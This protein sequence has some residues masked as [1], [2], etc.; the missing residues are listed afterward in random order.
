[1]A[2]N[3]D[4]A[5][6]LSQGVFIFVY[7]AV[8]TLLEFLIAKTFDA[9]AVLVV[10]ALVKGVLVVYYYMHIY[11]LNVDPVGDKASY[12]YKTGTNRLGL[13]LFLISDSFVF[14]GLLVMRMNLL[15]L[16]RPNLKRWFALFAMLPRLWEMVLRSRLG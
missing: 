3:Q 10:V 2:H 11:K 12:E 13:W 14:G 6:M 4:K 16:N 1:M 8:L 5:S 9:T 15:G 7:L